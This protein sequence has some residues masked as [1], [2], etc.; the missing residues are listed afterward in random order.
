MSEPF[1]AEV[2][3]VGFSFAPRGWAFCDG[4][5]LPVNQN[6]ALYSLSSAR[7]TG[8]MGARASGSRICGDGRPSTSDRAAE[9]LIRSGNR[10]AK[11]TT[12]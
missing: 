9:R 3:I 2:K 7:R 6:H 11:S 8:V 1:L 5:L 10:E 4:Q 12:R